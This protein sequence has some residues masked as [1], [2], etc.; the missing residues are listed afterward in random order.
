MAE[1]WPEARTGL[2]LVRYRLRASLRAQMPGYLSIVLLLGL[3]GGLALGSLEAARRTASSFTELWASTDP[4]QLAGIAGVLDPLIGS[5][6]GYDPA[7]ARAVRALPGVEAVGQQAGIDFLPLQA[8]GR[9]LD[10]PNF[11]PPS[12]GNGNGSVDGEFFHLDRV[13]VSQGRMADPR[14]ADEFMLSAT[15]AAALH[16]R[17]GDILPIG[18]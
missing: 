6:S 16:L 15:G 2:R 17:V 3:L 9:L 8:D 7:V 18:I 13:L 5:N 4:T 10:A 14:R 1:M 12:A 11:Y